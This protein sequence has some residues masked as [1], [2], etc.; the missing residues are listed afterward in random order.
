MEADKIING[1]CWVA[2]FDILG[3]KNEIQLSTGHLEVLAYLYGE[4]IDRIND[5]LKEVTG[6]MAL[7]YEC[8]WFSDSFL[9]Y[10]SDDSIDSYLTI[11]LAATSFFDYMTIIKK[12][13]VR[14]ALTAGD[15][16]ANK[17]KN[18]YLGKAVVDAYS[19]AEKQDWIGFVLTPEAYEKLVTNGHDPFVFVNGLCFIEYNVPIKRKAFASETERIELGYEKLF[20]HYYRD[21]DCR[22][23]L[24]VDSVKS[25]CNNKE[26]KKEYR[27]KYE[28]TL[29]FYEEI[30]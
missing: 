11:H 6:F 4:I 8:S 10:S 22:R 25:V 18:I 20:A 27:R 5:E 14:G 1:N 3:F 29:R 16:Y 28:N 30:S 7:K 19:Y 23:D 15:F 21:K 2:Y 9:F 13:P 17:N 26:V 12:W 24:I